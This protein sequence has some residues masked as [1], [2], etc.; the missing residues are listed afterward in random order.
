MTWYKNKSLFKTMM[1]VRLAHVLTIAL[2]MHLAR[3]ILA[4]VPQEKSWT[5]I[6]GPALVIIV[7]L[8]IIF[9]LKSLYR[10]FHNN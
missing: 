7:M 2:K 6:R 10:Q 9:A 3:D 4:P 1:T 5:L 8:T